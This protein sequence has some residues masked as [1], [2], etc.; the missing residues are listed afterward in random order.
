MPTKRKNTGARQKQIIVAAGS[1]ISKYGSEHLTVRRIAEEVGI[2]EAA[3]YRHFKNKKAILSFLLKHID[4]V[5]N[6]D[7]D[8]EILNNES[9]TLEA[10]DRIVLSYFSIVGM[11]KG[12]SWQVV[13]EVISFGDRLLNQQAFRM[14]GSYIAHLEAL[15][16]KGVRDG[17]LRKDININASATIL[18]SMIQGLVNLWSLSNGTLKLVETYTPLW[19]VYRETIANTES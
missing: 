6:E 1:L 15:L 16:A 5:L 18:F 12:V 9:I 4:E 13:A 2:S 8:R 19:R 7:I 3:I 14:I 11:G 10:I 17:A